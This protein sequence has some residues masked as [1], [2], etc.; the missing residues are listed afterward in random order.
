MGIEAAPPP[1]GNAPGRNQGAREEAEE[2][3]TYVPG[4][5]EALGIRIRR[6]LT[7]AM[8]LLHGRGLLNT[9]GGNA[10]AR[11]R[12][13]DGTEFIYITP[14]G[15][16]KPLL[17]PLSIA[18][19][20]PT[21]HRYWGR[22][23]SEL[24]LHLAVYRANPRATAVL[25]AHNPATVQAARLRLDLDP[26][27]LGVEARYYIGGC[28]SHIPPLPPGT[29]ELAEAAAKA[30]QACRVAVMEGHGAV[31]VSENPDP[32]QAVYEALD[33]LEA[34]EDLARAALL[35]RLLSHR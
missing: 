14:S 33:R 7:E 34:L 12:L 21:G 28:V 3:T 35:D 15:A 10:S 9:R 11:L 4:R 24:P 18:V 1:P 17:D 5:G 20:S 26:G 13:P 32:V 29:E 8:R 22:P 31:A 6:A 23:S 27:L 2:M 30:L 19:V 25:H 16:A